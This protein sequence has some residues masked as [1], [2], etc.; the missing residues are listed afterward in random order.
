MANKY[1]IPIK[2]FYFG[3]RDPKGEQIDQS[4][5]ADI[6]DWCDIPFEFQRMG[7]S[8]EQALAM[9]VP[10]NPE[11]PGEYQWEALT[12]GQAASLIQPVL[13]L[14]DRD[15]WDGVVERERGL[16]EQVRVHLQTFNL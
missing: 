2:V 16:A 7:L 3:D 12:D 13:D 10:E 4:A 1:G 6:E 14:I 15:A 8:A 5:L 9:G 11:K